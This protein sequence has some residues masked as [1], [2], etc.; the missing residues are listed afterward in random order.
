MN[1]ARQDSFL[2]SVLDAIGNTQR[3]EF[4]AQHADSTAASSPS[5]NISPWIFREG[6]H[7]IAEAG[8]I[9]GMS[10]RSHF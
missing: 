9:S 10:L 2:D 4:L 3:V 6:P 1:N 5:G 8:R 7:R